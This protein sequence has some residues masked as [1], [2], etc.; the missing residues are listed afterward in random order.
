MAGRKEEE[1]NV[2]ADYCKLIESNSQVAANLR[3]RSLVELKKSKLFA[4]TVIRRSKEEKDK[5]LLSIY[6]FIA[7]RRLTLEI[8]KNQAGDSLQVSS[9]V[10]LGAP[11][12]IKE[13]QKRREGNF[14][15]SSIRTSAWLGRLVGKR[16]LNC[17][18][19]MLKEKKRRNKREAERSFSWLV[20]HFVARS[21]HLREPF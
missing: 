11:G 1:K 8:G 19:A 5:K 12:I 15:Y 18:S 7:T 10:S 20:S 6:Y 13:V 14:I 4:G 16:F 3:S 9:G 17:R 21:S 2:P